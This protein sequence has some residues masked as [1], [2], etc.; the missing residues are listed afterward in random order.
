MKRQIKLQPLTAAAAIVLSSMGSF[1]QAAAEPEDDV[2]F[3]DPV[4]ISA[5]RTARPLSETS[6]SIAVVTDSEMQSRGYQTLNEA[7]L[8]IS[9]VTVTDP[10]NPLFSRIS[11]RG[12]D[13]NQ[14]TYVIDG[15][16]QDNYTLSGNRP[17]G[18]F[19]DPEL[20]RQIE[21]KHGGGSALYG[22]GGI[23]GTLAV[24]TKMASDFLEPGENFGV[25]VKTGYA[26][27]TKEWMRSAYVFG[28]TDIWD[29]L[30]AVSRR[31]S[32]DA[33]LSDDVRES[34][35]TDTEYTSLL[36]KTSLV[37][38]SSDFVL[39]LSY[40][41]D[42]YETSWLYGQTDPMA[43][44]LEQHRVTASVEYADGDLID[45]RANLQ[46]SKQDYSFDQSISSPIG[47]MGQ[48]NSDTLDA[49]AGNIQNSSRF[50]WLGSHTLTYGA[51]FSHTDQESLTYNPYSPT[52]QPDSTRPN[53]TSWDYGVFI[54][55]EIAFNDYVTFMPILRY[56]YFD[57]QSDN[58]S[59]EDFS[60]GKLTPGITISV[61]PMKGL[62]FWASANEGFRPPV[63]DELYYSYNLNFPGMPNAV[64]EANPD[65]K[66]EKSW[67]YEIGVNAVFSNLAADRDQLSIKA[68]A[69]YDD[70]KDFINIE[71][72]DDS[73]GATHYRAENYGHV[74]RKGA[75]L[76]GT[77]SIGNFAATAAYGL[78]HAT[79]KETDKRITGIT[80]QSLNVKLDYTI[81]K[82]FL[83]T[84]YRLSWNDAASG[85]K[86]KNTP[87][88]TVDYGSFTTHSI[89]F[90]WTPK[91]P[92]F[93]DFAAGVAVENI[94]NEKFRY[95]NGSYGYAR[96]IRLWMS[97]RF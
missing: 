21:V 72:W 96:G 91:I 57:R 80:P 74:V 17:V 16:R 97:G 42:D 6:S 23:G 85:D 54:Q 56:S 81:P 20:V 78:V 73:A 32:G 70:V 61:K 45:L 94:T 47:L 48:G 75:E 18:V 50:S 39:S 7:L 71:S 55:D 26:T 87:T 58:S 79:D 31:N 68:A 4:V 15:V 14:I 5:S 34:N 67:N 25:K 53:A 51:D 77:Y 24:T 10:D 49:W 33:K 89:G 41:Y 92:N 86:A 44:S 52:P 11:I 93:W 35:D 37:P 9:N 65:L 30:M 29:V 8:E 28:R 43:Y 12:S 63:L 13:S 90:T 64:V 66:P 84:W 69:F 83:N 62:S 59:Y 82:F 60:D 95:V 38:S 88:S 19:V 1:A 22:N 2:T 40:N 76:T 36:L 46:Y 3:V 27:T